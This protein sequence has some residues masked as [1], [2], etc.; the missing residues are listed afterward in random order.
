MTKPK[1]IHNRD[2]LHPCDLRLRQGTDFPKSNQRLGSGI[3]SGICPP[4]HGDNRNESS[5][6]SGRLEIQWQFDIELENPAF[7]VAVSADSFHGLIAK[8]C[9]HGGTCC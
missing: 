8:Y 9:L 2:S 1:S 3:A 5:R 7:V 4:Q 6:Q